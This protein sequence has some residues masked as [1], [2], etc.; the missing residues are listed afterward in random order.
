[1]QLFH[2]RAAGRL[3]EAGKDGVHEAGEARQDKADAEARGHHEMLAIGLADTA[4]MRDE[5]PLKHDSHSQHGSVVSKNSRACLEISPK[6]DYQFPNRCDIFPAI[7]RNM[8]ELDRIDRHILAALQEDCSRSLAELGEQVAL[9]PNACWRRIKRL[10]EAGVIRGRVAL[11]DPERLG[12]GITVFVAI[13]TSQHTAEW[14]ERFASG[15]QKIPEVVEFYRM[16]GDVDYLLK[17]L[18]ADI[19]HYDRVYKRLIT[20]ASLSGVNS[21]FA[22]EK[23]KCTTAVPL[24]EMGL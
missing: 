23:I 15:V 4:R 24:L 2:R 18:V 5:E 19:A 6:V 7:W 10:E 13:R 11:L 3:E 21:S 1:M 22:M 20:V 8:V 12:V 14:L 17:I 9:S 16:S